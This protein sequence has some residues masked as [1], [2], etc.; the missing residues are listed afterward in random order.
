MFFQD[1]EYKIVYIYIVC[2]H[3]NMYA[4]LKAYLGMGIKFIFI[5]MKAL[6]LNKAFIYDKLSC[7]KRKYEYFVGDDR[8]LK[9]T[10][11]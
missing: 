7:L 3:G 5:I 10:R 1:F 8:R 2:M 9:V 6:C 11:D 4:C